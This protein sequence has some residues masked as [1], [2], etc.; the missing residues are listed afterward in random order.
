MTASSVNVANSEDRSKLARK[1]A[2]CLPSSGAEGLTASGFVDEERA[3]EV[4]ERA[5]YNRTTSANTKTERQTDGGFAG[6]AALA[7]ATAERVS[8]LPSSSSGGGGG[9][10]SSSFS[11]LGAAAHCHQYMGLRGALPDGF[12]AL[13][14]ASVF[15]FAAAVVA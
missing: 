3:A 1:S 11:S 8:E 15:G 9:G 6:L 14:F 2:S 5:Y 12:T 7:G 4:G 13:G 10:G